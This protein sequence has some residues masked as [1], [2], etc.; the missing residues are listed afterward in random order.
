MMATRKTQRLAPLAAPA[1]VL[2]SYPIKPE[3][4]GEN[5]TAFNECGDLLF[6]DMI[7]VAHRS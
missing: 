6:Q 3:H 7:T 1:V 2:L 5:L 4:I